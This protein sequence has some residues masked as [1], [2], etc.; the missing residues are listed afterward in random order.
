MNT[1]DPFDVDAER[2]TGL[3]TNVHKSNKDNGELSLNDSKYGSRQI[4]QNK[5]LTASMT[6]EESDMSTMDPETIK[7]KTFLG[8]RMKS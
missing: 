4:M 2:T 3:L 5:A 1:P 6:S 8:V 7:K